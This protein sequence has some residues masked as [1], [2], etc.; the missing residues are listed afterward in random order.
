M[1]NL[2]PFLALAFAVAVI[3]GAG[4]E[5]GKVAVKKAIALLKQNDDQK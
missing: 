3:D 2:L 5:V 4:N 1:F